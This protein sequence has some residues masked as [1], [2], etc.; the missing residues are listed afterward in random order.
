[1]KKIFYSVLSILAAVSCAKQLDVESG[2]VSGRANDAVAVI[3]A[4][5]DSELI[6]DGSLSR[7]TLE[8]KDG[9]RYIRWAKDD[10]IGIYGG[11]STVNVQADLDEDYAG[12]TKG[13]FLIGGSF[14]D[15]SFAYY[16]YSKDVIYVNNKL[17]MVQIPTVQTYVKGKVFDG[18]S[19]VMVGRYDAS[20]KSFNFKNACSIIEIQLT[21]D[22]KI[23]EIELRSLSA[24]IAGR[25]AVNTTGD[26]VFNFDDPDAIPS[27]KVGLKL[28][29]PV[30][31]SSA[32]TPFYF[33][34]ASGTYPDLIVYTKGEGGA[35]QKTST[36]GHNVATRHI[37]PMKAFNASAPDYSGAADISAAKGPAN[38]Y[39]VD[40]GKTGKFSFPVKHVDGKSFA[41]NEPSSVKNGSF[42]DVVWESEGCFIGD[43]YYDRS[44]NR[45]CFTKLRAHEGT[46]LIC[47][48]NEE[49]TVLWSWLIWCSEVNDQTWGATPYTFQDRFI[50][51]TWVPKNEEEAM[52][53][54]DAQYVAST[55]LLYQ[56]GRYIP[57]PGC[58]TMKPGCRY[59]GENV[60]TGATNKDGR[61]INA[62]VLKKFTW[63][64]VFHRF[65]EEIGDGWEPR[66]QLWTY[67]QANEHPL[68]MNK[69]WAGDSPMWTKSYATDIAATGP[70]ALWQVN[71]TNFDPCPAGYRVPQVKEMQNFFDDGN[72]QL[73][74]TNGS[75]SSK[76]RTSKYLG[77]FITREGNFIWVP[78]AGLRT[79]GNT[80]GS[81]G[82]SYTIAYWGNYRHD[83][84]TWYDGSA[85]IWTFD[86]SDTQITLNGAY[87]YGASSAWVNPATGDAVQRFFHMGGDAELGPRQFTANNKPVICTVGDA[88]SV[89]CV[90]IQ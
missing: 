48:F 90:K 71:K 21:G 82:Y 86:P 64:P 87:G 34:V 67:E 76:G 61:A 56:Y 53:G 77:A 70:N 50:G 52:D 8:D 49:K 12:E 6:Y 73:V 9:N 36:A 1:M 24:P 80:T 33:V 2:D 66:N 89:R 85:N 15:P 14:D 62:D 41:S 46:A 39:I 32:P 84:V 78:K 16:P 3:T 63:Q 79:H 47:L 28:T 58:N 72:G 57:T 13:A 29:E 18:T 31:L 69:I 43:I 65:Y 19:C 35:F 44:A 22:S 11:P 68:S 45:I 54:T 20:A 60:T 40:P 81:N 27:Y 26:P 59:E 4:T 83:S 25:G 38:T 37:L 55:G 88:L 7:T 23:T 42:A 75:A 17:S 5:I 10:V 30:Q 74:W 51:A